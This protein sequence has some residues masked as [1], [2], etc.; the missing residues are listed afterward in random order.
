MIVDVQIFP[1]GKL[2]S[3]AE[4]RKFTPEDSFAHSNRKI[5]IVLR[6]A[7]KRVEKYSYSFCSWGKISNIDK[8]FWE[9]FLGFISLL[10]TYGKIKDSFTYT[11]SKIRL[12]ADMQDQNVSNVELWSLES[13]HSSSDWRWGARGALTWCSLIIAMKAWGK[14]I[15]T[16]LGETTQ[17]H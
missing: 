6:V 7:S 10:K 1:V 5:L 17:I 13:S 3:S 15:Y 11:R 4:L 9:V 14:N 16:F 2:C 12:G 8:V